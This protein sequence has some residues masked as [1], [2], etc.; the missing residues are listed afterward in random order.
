MRSRPWYHDTVLF[1]HRLRCVQWLRGRATCKSRKILCI[2]EIHTGSALQLCWFTDYL[3][4]GSGNAVRIPHCR[5][6]VRLLSNQSAS[7]VIV[8]WTCWSRSPRL[9]WHTIPRISQNIQVS[10]R[11]VRHFHERI[12]ERIWTDCTVQ[13]S[14]VVASIVTQASNTTTHAIPARH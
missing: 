4:C 11:N 12:C 3:I 7:Q 14:T 5:M 10:V 9:C 6:Y 1:L 8:H 13:G 2:G